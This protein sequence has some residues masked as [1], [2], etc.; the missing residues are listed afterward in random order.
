MQFVKAL[1]WIF[2]FYLGFEQ[3]IG[4]FGGVAKKCDRFTFILV[5]SLVQWWGFQNFSRS[6]RSSQ[7]VERVRSE[8][9]AGLGLTDV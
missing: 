2:N 8:N 4:D 9:L 7:K 3:V 5:G 6:L 1:Y